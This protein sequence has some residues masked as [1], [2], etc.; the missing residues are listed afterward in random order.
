MILFWIL[1]FELSVA[2]GEAASETFRT[3][4]QHVHPKHVLFL[5]SGYRPFIGFGGLPFW[6]NLH[7]CGNPCDGRANVHHAEGMD[8]NGFSYTCINVSHLSVG[9]EDPFSDSTQERICAVRLA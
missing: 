4:C 5:C 2:F 3:C 6:N 1:D 7:F 8:T 9:E